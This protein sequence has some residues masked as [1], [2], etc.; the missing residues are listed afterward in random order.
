M[1]END[2]DKESEKAKK[3]RR[4]LLLKTDQELKANSR[5]YSNIMINSKTSQELNKV[6]NSYKIL[7]S[8]SSP[9]YSNYGLIISKIYPETYRPQNKEKES[10]KAKREEQNNKS[11]NS[12]YESHSPAIDFIPNKIDLGIKKFSFRK[13][14]S[15]RETN[16]PKFF[17]EISNLENK[18]KEEEKEDTKIKSS[19][20]GNKNINKVIDKIVRIKLTTDIED[21][22]NITKSVII[23]RKYCYKLIKKRK[24]L[25]KNTKP[26]EPSPN[27]KTKKG[28]E[29]PKVRK[30]RTL[31]NIHTFGKKS[32]FGSKDNSQDE[33]IKR[34]DTYE[35]INKQLNVKI[36]EE[37]KK[38]EKD[39]CI[40]FNN[41]LEKKRAFKMNSY[42]DLQIIREKAKEEQLNI[43]KK[44]RLRRV[45]TL[46]AKNQ[47]PLMNK[48][49]QKKE[50]NKIES[51][52]NQVNPILKEQ[53]ISTKVA[54]PS[55]FV[56][57]NNNI[58]NANIIIKN[59]VKKK[60][61]L[62][63]N[64][65]SS[66]FRNQKPIKEKDEEKN[67]VRS[68]LRRNGKNTVKLFS[69][70]FKGFKLSSGS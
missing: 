46:N 21:D 19:K 10:P 38:A 37:I 1:N 4:K 50:P 65:R 68:S 29:R 60:N 6:Y 59:E 53:I 67:K 47:P 52:L 58:N 25:K 43:D 8:E 22:N 49:N 13:K 31:A 42:K 24:K 32:L 57:I 15:I 23:L 7:L 54:R 55:K 39:I 56:I 35:K 9:I 16:S 20:I 51:T 5:K 28:E 63:V 3:I 48:L 2:D 40:S 66:D 62:F 11:P 61:S 33:I 36:T 18:N 45:Q 17:K 30:R 27:K 26:R 69:P 12:S 14:G 34:E 64:K 70:R 41:N 44:K